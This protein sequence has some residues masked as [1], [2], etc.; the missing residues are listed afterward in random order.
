MHRLAL[1]LDAVF[2]NSEYAVPGDYDGI[3]APEEPDR[4]DDWR[5]GMHA[6]IY[7]SFTIGA[8]LSGVY[9]EAYAKADAT[10][11]IAV[12]Q[13]IDTVQRRERRD[14]VLNSFAVLRDSMTEEEEDAA[15][16]PQADW[17]L[18][19]LRS[20]QATASMME[21]RFATGSGRARSCLA[22]QAASDAG[23]PAQLTAGGTHAE[24]HAVALQLLHLLWASRHIMDM[25]DRNAAENPAHHQHLQAVPVGP[26]FPY[27]VFQS[28][29]AHLPKL[30]CE[31]S[32]LHCSFAAPPA[33]W[34]NHLRNGYWFIQSHFDEDDCPSGLTGND[35]FPA[36]LQA[37]FFVYF[38]RKHM[39]LAFHPQFFQT[40]HTVTWIDNDWD[41]F[42][43]SLLIF[44]LDDVEGREAYYPDCAA[45]Q[46]FPYDG[47][48]DGADLLVSS[49]RLQEIAASSS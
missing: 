43:H 33:A 12:P 14:E 31:P 25:L 29:I 41:A 21:A 5:V 20:D 6:A 26:V 42:H 16:G 2:Q 46:H 18:H 27:G 37:R 35:V 34:V 22:R 24:A 15:F 8:A 3:T 45:S 13:G 30:D 19:D 47:F 17:L 38:L 40:N 11:E 36:F 23:C 39:K 10:P 32:Y 49:D 4:M 9:G 1:A 44:S 7:R 48:L 28:R